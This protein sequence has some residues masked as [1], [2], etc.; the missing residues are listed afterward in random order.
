MCPKR[1]WIVGVFTL[2][3]GTGLATGEFMQQDNHQRHLELQRQLERL[4]HDQ[5]RSPVPAPTQID[6]WTWRYNEFIKELQ[7][8]HKEMEAGL[9]SKKRWDRVQKKFESLVGRKLPKG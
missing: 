4:R 1:L 6:D 5:M 2:I 7:E 9:F 8:F 3:L